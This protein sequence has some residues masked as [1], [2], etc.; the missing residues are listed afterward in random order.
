MRIISESSEDKWE[1]GNQD[2]HAGRSPQSGDEGYLDGWR[3]GNAVELEAT[4]CIPET[5]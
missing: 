1:R 4:L 2:A 3:T 5:V